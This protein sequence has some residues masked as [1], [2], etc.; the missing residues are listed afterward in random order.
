MGATT[1]AGTSQVTLREAT[2]EDAEACSRIVFEAFG[3]IH[4][5]HRFPRDFPTPEAAAGMIGGW[6]PHPEVWGV[7]RSSTAA[8]SGRTSSTSA[9]RSAA[10][11]R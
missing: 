2:P 9:I 11:D 4:D 7:V 8:S 6:I 10:S 5:H 3:E 1:A